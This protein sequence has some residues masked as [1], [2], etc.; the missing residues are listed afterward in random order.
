MT[1]EMYTGFEICPD[2]K[3]KE[4]CFRV[5][6]YDHNKVKYEEVF[7]EHIP[8]RRISLDSELEALRAL[9]DHF[10]GWPAT[11]ILHSRLN[12]RPGG[13]SRYPVFVC[14]VE[15]PEKGV[16]RRY[17]RSGDALAWS[18]FVISQGDFRQSKK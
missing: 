18:D 3:L 5:Q 14:N 4:K 13:P 15:Y 17:V 1:K 10:A 11:F 2:L 6:L 16:I 7:H 8:M 12:N 9:V